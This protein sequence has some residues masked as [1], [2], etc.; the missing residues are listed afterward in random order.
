MSGCFHR[1]RNTKYLQYFRLLRNVKEDTHFWSFLRANEGE[2]LSLITSG[3]DEH[4]TSEV[5]SSQSRNVSCLIMSRFQ[6]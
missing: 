3:E 1:H 2:K 6:N 5:T 4:G